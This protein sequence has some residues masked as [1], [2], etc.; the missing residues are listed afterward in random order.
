MQMECITILQHSFQQRVQNI[1]MVYL[2]VHITNNIWFIYHWLKTIHRYIFAVR[3]L[4]VVKYA[5]ET[6][7]EEMPVLDQIS[8]CVLIV[9]GNFCLVCNDIFAV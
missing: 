8:R 9:I 5:H 3:A 1:E 2:Q 6:E 7:T 4:F